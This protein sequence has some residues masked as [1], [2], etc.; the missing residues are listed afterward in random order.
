MSRDF[1]D[2]NRQVSVTL[3]EADRFEHK[4]VSHSFGETKEVSLLHTLTNEI[5]IEDAVSFI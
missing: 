4:Q 3:W 2:L 1:A 5:Y